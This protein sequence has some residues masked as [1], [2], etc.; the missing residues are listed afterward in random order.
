M[1]VTSFRSNNYS[2]VGDAADGRPVTRSRE[3]STWALYAV[4]NILSADNAVRHR[5]NRGTTTFGFTVLKC[6]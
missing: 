2:C 1:D 6:C 4:G 3:T 5:W